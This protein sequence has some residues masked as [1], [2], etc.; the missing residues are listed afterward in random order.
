ME[1]NELEQVKEETVV[2]NAKKPSFF[3]AWKKIIRYSRPWYVPTA[4]SFIFAA[5]AAILLLLGTSRIED[6]VDYIFAGVLGDPG[7]HT[8]VVEIGIVLAIFY[9]SM[10]VLNFISQFLIA[11]VVG[12]IG[13]TLRRRI[14]HKVNKLPLG[15]FDKTPVGDTL[16]RVTND[17]DTISQAMSFAIVQFVA[18]VTQAL[19]AIVF[20]FI[21]NWLLAVVAIVTSFIG[22][23][24]TGIIMTKSQKHFDKQQEDLAKVNSHIEEYYTG[25]TVVRTCNAS[26]Q[27]S[28][29]FDELNKELYN[30]NWKSGFFSG[31]MM[32]IMMFMAQIGFVA[33][34]IVGGVLVFNGTIGFGVMATFMIFVRLFTWPLADIAESLQHM[35]RAA[36]ASTRVFDFLAEEEMEDESNL[37]ANLENVKGQVEFTNVQ[38]GY[39]DGV[40]VINNFSVSIPA[41]SKVAIVGPTG[42]GKTTLV[43]LLMKFYKVSG[44]DI[45]I[46]GV[47]INDLSRESVA[48]LFGMVLQDTWLFEGTVRE[49][50]LY[51]NAHIVDHEVLKDATKAAGIHHFI[52][53]LPKGY[54]TILDEKTSVSAGE[55]QLLTIARAMV[56]NAPLLILDEATSSVDTR[57]EILIQEAMDKLTINHTSFIIAHR[58]S[59]IKNADIIL[60]MNHGDI[61]ESGRHEEL[62]DKGGFYADL[63][64]SQFAS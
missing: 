40:P 5:I 34:C 27:V 39:K 1:E 53:T 41:G 57:T 8:R 31:L 59:T 17:T 33:I 6:M 28:G 25:H 47:S 44:G 16:S 14:S 21:M 42:A 55:R 36:A 10:L 46:D 48:R 49:N 30:S 26:K 19:G 38:F 58:L 50:L 18:A 62:L 54:E 56:K 9:G 7:A 43:N 32:P 29:E 60:V 64:N 52:K 4:F 37:T 11:G 23:A 20:M 15:Y 61:V 45:K 35:Q 22:F 24:L 12:G 3:V 13:I 63:Y 2:E 51:N